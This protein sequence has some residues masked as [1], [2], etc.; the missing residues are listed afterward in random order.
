MRLLDATR[1]AV[2]FA[3]GTG[4]SPM[5]AILL[6]QLGANP[7]AEAVLLLSARHSSELLFRDAFEA[8]AARHAGFR[9]VPIVSRDDAGWSGRRGRVAAHVDE[10]MAGLNSPDTYFCGQ[11]EM[12][13]QLRERLAAAGIPDEHQVYERY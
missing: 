11:R 7:A 12:V 9:F 1:P 3:A 8:L 13:T 2:Y 6:A 4:V 5:R 10:A